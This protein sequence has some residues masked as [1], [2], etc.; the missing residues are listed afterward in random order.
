[1]SDSLHGKIN[2]GDGDPLNL[3]E[4][5]EI[6][7][8][9]DLVATT[10]VAAMEAEEHA[11]DSTEEEEDLGSRGGISLHPGVVPIGQLHRANLSSFQHQ[12][13]VGT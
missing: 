9:A 4:A 7:D 2:I 3:M 8:V 6:M 13:C 11:A 12:A 5:E 1:M 10:V